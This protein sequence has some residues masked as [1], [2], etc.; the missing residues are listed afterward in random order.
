VCDVIATP[1]ESRKGNSMLVSTTVGKSLPC[2][3]AT[4]LCSL[5][6]KGQYLEKLCPAHT[7]MCQYPPPPS[8]H[9]HVFV[10]FKTHTHLR[11][12]HECCLQLLPLECCCISQAPAVEHHAATLAGQL[13]GQ[14][15]LG[16]E[17]E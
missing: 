17:A 14:D 15:H 12:L 4:A 9:T 10:F 16:V 8:T 2:S 7:P 3:T 1:G 5:Q 11:R 6:P 13:L